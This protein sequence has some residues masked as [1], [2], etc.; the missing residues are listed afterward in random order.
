MKL[1]NLFKQVHGN[2]IFNLWIRCHQAPFIRIISNEPLGLVRD[3]VMNDTI[4]IITVRC[5]ND[6]GVL[7]YEAASGSDLKAAQEWNKRHRHTPPEDF[8]YVPLLTIPLR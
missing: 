3:G 5:W 8:K 2:T 4:T 1:P 7:E 6:N